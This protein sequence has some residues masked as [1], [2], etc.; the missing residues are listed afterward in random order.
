MNLPRFRRVLPWLLLA[1]G[2]LAPGW[3]IASSR[4]GLRDWR[5]AAPENSTAVLAF[6]ANRGSMAPVAYRQIAPEDR[7]GR[8]ALWL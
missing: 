6:A 7:R 1:A 5:Q 4:F 3:L 2:L 8:N